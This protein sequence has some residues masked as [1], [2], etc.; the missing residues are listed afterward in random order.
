MTVTIKYN[1]QLAESTISSYMKDWT[2][3]N[4]NI[5]TATDKVYGQ[6]ADATMGAGNQYSMGSSHQADTGMILE[7][8]LVYNCQQ[9]VFYGTM[10]SLELGEVFVPNEGGLGRHFE[11]PQLKVSGLDVT[12]TLGEAREGEVHKSVRG[13]QEGNPD[14]MLALLKTIGIDVDTQLK[15]MAIASQ[16][17][18]M[19][20]DMP[21]IDTVGVVESSDMLL[22]A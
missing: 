21:M 22:A 8:A 17:E 19:A 14:P 6:F 1:S 5:T 20:S 10:E 2:E 11:L 7:G 3:K 12:S 9:H 18:V 4:G 13:L 15:D 16:F